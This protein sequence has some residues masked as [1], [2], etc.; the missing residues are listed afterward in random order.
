MEESIRFNP[1][2]T[3]VNQNQNNMRGKE[4][5]SKVLNKF[6]SSNKKFKTFIKRESSKSKIKAN[7]YKTKNEEK[8]NKINNP[9]ISKQPTELAAL[10]DFMFEGT[11]V[12]NTVNN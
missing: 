6:D 11:I 3:S 2:G 10:D 8:I 4:I 1:V 5:C 9:L 12:K 7:N